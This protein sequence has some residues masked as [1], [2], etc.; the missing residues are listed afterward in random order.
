MSEYSIKLTE[1]NSYY[2]GDSVYLHR[3]DKELWL[4]C[5]F[6][7]LYFSNQICLSEEVLNNLLRHLK[8]PKWDGDYE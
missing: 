7:G 5:T 2:L 8:D 6:N 4:I 3:K 1:E